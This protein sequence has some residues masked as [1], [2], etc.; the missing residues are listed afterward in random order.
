M[1]IA[2]LDSHKQKQIFYLTSYTNSGQNSLNTHIRCKTVI[3][4]EE[5]IGENLNN[6]DLDN[7]LLNMTTQAQTTKAKT[8]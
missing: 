5:N 3:L 2:K 6:I 1:V 4:L 8:R 7:N